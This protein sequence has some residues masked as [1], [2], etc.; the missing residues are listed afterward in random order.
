MIKI[1]L[2]RKGKVHYPTYRL[3]VA[4]ARDTLNGYALDDLGFYNPH[5][6]EMKVDTDKASDWI[7]KGAQPTK[8]V[9]YVL[10]KSGLEFK[11][12]K[13]VKK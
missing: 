3:V 13:K 6:K 1:K 7:K 8:T 5:T 10:F 11:N 9:Q 2:R 12:K 4:E